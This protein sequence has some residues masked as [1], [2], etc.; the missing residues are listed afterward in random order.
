MLANFPTLQELAGLREEV[1][2]VTDNIK[3][4]LDHVTQQKNKE[5]SKLEVCNVK[6]VNCTV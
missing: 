3:A 4:E 5:I 1:T 6:M 2:T